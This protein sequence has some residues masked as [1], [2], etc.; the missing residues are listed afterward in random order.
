MDSGYTSPPLADAQ[1]LLVDDEELI[2]SAYESALQLSGYRRITCCNDAREVEGLV[3]SSQYAV[4]LLDVAMPHISGIS[5]IPIIRQHQSGTPIIIATAL[6][7]MKNLTGLPEHEIQDYLL[8][9]IDRAQLVAA[10]DRALSARDGA[11]VTPGAAQDSGLL[12]NWMLREVHHR[13]NNNLQVIRS[14]ISLHDSTPGRDPASV[15]VAVKTR[16]ETIAAVHRHLCALSEAAG[17]DVGDLA[18]TVADHVQQHVASTTRNPTVRVECAPHAVPHEA[19]TPLAMIVHELVANSLIHAYR[20]GDTAIL[21]I[22][23][24]RVSADTTYRLEISDDGRGEPPYTQT[25]GLGLTLVSLFARQLGAHA[26]CTSNS[27]RGTRHA[28]EIPAVSR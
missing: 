27:P 5:L 4:I 25:H 24:E 22:R 14:L 13:V 18:R 28:F 21:T 2:L 6:G 23:G 7:P 19:A 15:L 17:V 20:P 1:I 11:A 9:P 3:R 8:K 26:S 10:I 16:I 12:Q